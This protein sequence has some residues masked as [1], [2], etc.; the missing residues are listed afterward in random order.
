MEMAE[1]LFQENYRKD[2][3]KLLADCYYLPNEEL[4]KK[5]SSLD[6]S[7]GNLFSEIAEN[8]SSASNIEALLIDYSKLFL[9]PYKLLAPPYGSVYLE[10]TRRI[11]GNSTLDVRSKYAEE[12]LNITIKE[13]P[14]HITIELEFMYYLISR[15]VE[16]AFDSDST[17]VVRYLEKQKDF[18]DVHLG[19]W[20]NEF[21]SNIEINA[22]T[23]FYRVLARQ[24]KLFIETERK[25]ITQ[26]LLSP[27][28]YS[29]RL[30]L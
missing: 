13:A 14:D 19:E 18:L 12:G 4:I 9:G 27:P 16:A 2:S 6:I 21:T 11:M 22:E 25:I 3:Y 15:E 1:F 7:R 26:S 17:N 5:L 29:E 24:T 23:S 20:I 28:R 10:N 30:K 8:A